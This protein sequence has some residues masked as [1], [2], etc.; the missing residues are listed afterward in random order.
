M[1]IFNVSTI[2]SRIKRFLRRLA[3][4]SMFLFTLCV[5]LSSSLYQRSVHILY[6]K[7][8]HHFTKYPPLNDG[9]KSNK[10][11]TISHLNCKLMECRRN[12]KRERFYPVMIT[13]LFFFLQKHRKLTRNEWMLKMLAYTSSPNVSECA[14][15]QGSTETFWIVI[16]N[17]CE[18]TLQNLI[19]NGAYCTCLPQCSTHTHTA[20]GGGS[21]V[22]SDRSKC[23][24]LFGLY[25]A[26]TPFASH[27]DVLCVFL[28]SSQQARLLLES[29]LLPVG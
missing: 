19:S 21:F 22:C 18:R 28:D 2:L 16:H 5:F 3:L 26:S 24:A 29:V 14:A 23:L 15:I 9:M 13:V 6:F 8:H 7:W 4:V 11:L 10:S 1:K 20:G 27:G 12:G 17:Q 25:F